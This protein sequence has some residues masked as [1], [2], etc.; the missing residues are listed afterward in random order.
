MNSP[1]KKGEQLESGTHAEAL[2]GINNVAGKPVGASASTLAVPSSATAGSASPPCVTVE[3]V[4]FRDGQTSFVRVSIGAGLSH[5]LIDCSATPWAAPPVGGDEFAT[6]VKLRAPMLLSDPREDFACIDTVLIT[7]FQSFAALPLLLQ[8]PELAQCRVFATAPA[9]QLGRLH[10]ENLLETA[11]LESTFPQC[12]AAAAGACNTSPLSCGFRLYEFQALQQSL[13][14]VE[15]VSY[16][17]T[18]I[19]D[20]RLSLTALASG[21]S[22]GGAIWVV[23]GVVPP[24]L[25]ATSKGQPNADSE[26]PLT[27]RLV[28]ANQMSAVTKRL[29]RPLDLTALRT[30]H[31]LLVMSGHASHQNKTAAAAG[32]KTCDC[33]Q[34]GF[35]SSETATAGKSVQP[36]Q[37][38]PTKKRSKTRSAKGS[39]YAA[40]FSALCADVSHRLRRGHTVVLPVMP[41]GGFFQEFL[42]HLRGLGST[43]GGAA[44]GNRDSHMPAAEKSGSVSSAKE[45]TPLATCPLIFVGKTL[46]KSVSLIDTLSEWTT[47][48]NTAAADLSLPVSEQ[49]Q[50]ADGGMSWDEILGQR[51]PSTMRADSRGAQSNDERF[52]QRFVFARSW[53]AVWGTVCASRRFNGQN[54]SVRQG[55]AAAGANR[56]KL[57]SIVFVEH[58]PSLHNRSF[59]G[60]CRFLCLQFH[61]HCGHDA[62]PSPGISV[63]YTHLCP[64]CV[65][66]L[67]SKTIAGKCHTSKPILHSRL[68]TTTFALPCAVQRKYLRTSARTFDAIASVCS[69][70]ISDRSVSSPHFCRALRLTSQKALRRCK[71]CRASVGLPGQPIVW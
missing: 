69:H 50:A 7:S 1:S 35:R 55:Y 63:A 58:R 14:R 66:F 31:N 2:N 17:E 8:R 26:C 61:H 27:L 54:N 37:A 21:A 24:V 10:L 43:V 68:Y 45:R 59:L 30:E 41:A 42:H 60:L 47:R 38:R 12:F 39:G 44:D 28:L 57:G 29:A 18:V 25:G 71:K 53:G 4:G 16:G 11:A 49:S 64:G 56:L 6:F 22:V 9:L 23:H 34:S 32:F 51:Q 15:V 67:R 13:S 33:R 70:T 40:C 48:I 20:G 65:L 19:I 5:V 36:P 52:R 62:E 46:F 3:A